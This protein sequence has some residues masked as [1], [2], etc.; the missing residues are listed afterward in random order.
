MGVREEAGRKAV[1]SWAKRIYVLGG[2]GC[3]AIEE[4]LLRQ[5][6]LMCGMNQLY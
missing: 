2:G 1:G 3:R 4:E 5:R 6:V